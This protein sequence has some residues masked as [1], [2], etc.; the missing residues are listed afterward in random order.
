M[1][2]LKQSG[3]NNARIY[4]VD[5][6]SNSRIELTFLETSAISFP[7]LYSSFVVCDSAANL[8]N[9]PSDM[10]ISQSGS[11]ITIGW[12]DN[13]SDETGFKIN[14]R[15]KINNGSCKN[16]SGFGQFTFCCK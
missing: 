12:T 7:A 2:F 4:S 16:I 1:L 9:P 8:S 14:R 5:V 15:T 3:D 11:S 6:V 13:S 10:T